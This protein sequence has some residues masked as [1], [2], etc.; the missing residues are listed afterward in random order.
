VLM[1]P[2]VE[3]TIQAFAKH[4]RAGLESSDRQPV[5]GM[6]I[7]GI[8]LPVRPGA[9]I[10]IEALVRRTRGYYEQGGIMYFK[11][12]YLAVLPMHRT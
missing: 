5:D 6:P 11:Q 9:K 1:R 10:S 2:E 8:A 12:F 4:Y 3:T 7:R